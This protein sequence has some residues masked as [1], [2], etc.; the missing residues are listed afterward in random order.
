MSQTKT[1]RKSKS[2]TGPASP[3]L[4][5]RCIAGIRAAAIPKLAP[6]PDFPVKV[7]NDA[8]TVLLS[9]L[10]N[11]GTW[12]VTK[13]AVINKTKLSGDRTTEALNYL[14]AVNIVA[15]V[16]VRKSRRF[17][18]WCFRVDLDGKVEKGGWVVHHS[19]VKDVYNDYG[20]AKDSMR[21]EF[22]GLEAKKP[23]A[24]KRRRRQ[25]P[26]KQGGS[27][28]ASPSTSY[29][30]I[31]VGEEKERP[32]LSP[33]GEIQ[34][35]FP[36][37]PKAEPQGVMEEA[38]APNPQES[39]ITPVE[40]VAEDDEE[41]DD[42]GYSMTPDEVVQ[43]GKRSQ[44][45]LRCIA[46]EERFEYPNI[47][48]EQDSL[49]LQEFE[50]A[51]CDMLSSEPVCV[52]QHQR[53]APRHPEAL[54]WFNGTLMGLMIQQCL[55][56]DDQLSPALAATFCQKLRRGD[57][58]VGHFV[59]YWTMVKTRTI[60]P[61][62]SHDLLHIL[63]QCAR[64]NATYG[65]DRFERAVGHLHTFCDKQFCS[66]ARRGGWAH[67]VGDSDPELLRVWEPGYLVSGFCKNQIALPIV[68]SAALG[69]A[70]RVMAI[71]H[72]IGEE[73]MPEA[74]VWLRSV[75]ITRK[76]VVTWFVESQEGRNN[77]QAM[78]QAM[79]GGS[80]YL[81]R[82]DLYRCFGMTDKE[83]H[84]RVWLLANML[85]LVTDDMNFLAKA[86]CDMGFNELFPSL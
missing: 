16:A 28:A 56:S 17:H 12:Q 41:Y 4:L 71:Q 60:E 42:E 80:M 46:A 51:S 34:T 40:L 5:P 13:R 81:N 30:D 54:Q 47:C 65:E 18:G 22:A 36:E 76:Q 29:N 7:V 32:L 61:R 55:T 14:R 74:S 26:L 69:W 77:F 15:D 1:P 45:W 48:P 31:P 57:L 72:L 11:Q 73:H 64:D 20:A 78:V 24:S 66:S 27:E 83:H 33:A 23:K 43:E 44:T 19:Q 58:T 62:K 79:T 59:R 70:A 86:G 10:D 50:G 75:G 68:G 39:T 52:I 63:E 25:S 53:C 21:R 67:F 9:I 3:I 49:G 2:K 6:T 37:T 82:L 84:G 85:Q 38:Q 35:F 8:Q